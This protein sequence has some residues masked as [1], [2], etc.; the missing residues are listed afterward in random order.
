MAVKNK[1]QAKLFLTPFAHDA[2]RKYKEHT[3]EPM[4]TTVENLIREVLIP[5]MRRD[6]PE[7]DLGIEERG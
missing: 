4:S 7:L 5:E 3:G 2:L 6:A 1:Q